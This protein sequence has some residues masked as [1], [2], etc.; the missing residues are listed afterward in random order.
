M[1]SQLFVRH[2]NPLLI[3]NRSRILTIHKDRIFFKNLLEKKEM[4]FQNGVKSI[5]AAAYNGARM[6]L[7]LEFGSADEVCSI[8]LGL[9]ICRCKTLWVCAPA[10][11]VLTHS[12]YLCMGQQN[13]KAVARQITFNSTEKVSSRENAISCFVVRVQ[14]PKPSLS[15][16]K[17]PASGEISKHKIQRCKAIS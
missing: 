5:Q 11:P 12:L 3:R 6:V 15:E 13:S 1:K 8:D 9:K 10:A 4:V 14:I 2:Y 16:G 7:Y 17:S